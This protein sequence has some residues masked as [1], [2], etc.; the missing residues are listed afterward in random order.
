VQVVVLLLLVA[1]L[2]LLVLG[3]ITGSTPLVVG[4]IAASLLAGYA[5]SRYRRTAQSGGR[6]AP[7][8]PAEARVAEARVA[9]P[10]QPRAITVA[11]L[12]RAAATER[13]GQPAEPA[14][15]AAVPSAAVPGA[16]VAAEAGVRAAE[17]A[18]AGVR[19]D[20]SQPA[21]AGVRVTDQPEPDGQPGS[22]GADDADDVDDAD[23]PTADTDPPLRSRGDEPVLVID[24]RPRYHLTG[25]AFLLG[26]EPEPVPLRQAVEDGFS[27]CALCDPDT[28][29]ATR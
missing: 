2:A 9:E 6:E 20:P 29:L 3:L 4:S 13:A 26:R 12:A 14:H 24:G 25:C 17:P 8:V 28:G 21:E 22:A 16:A 15:A 18:E 10:A 19:A 11:E 27:P 7:S 5:I 23:P 1:G